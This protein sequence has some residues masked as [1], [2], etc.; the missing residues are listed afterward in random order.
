MKQEKQ[1]HMP[2]V[3]QPNLTFEWDAEK[4]GEPLN[5]TLGISLLFSTKL[6]VQFHFFLRRH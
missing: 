5:F 1:Q 4:R 2:C 6:G 3:P